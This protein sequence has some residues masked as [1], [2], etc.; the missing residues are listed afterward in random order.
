MVSSRWFLSTLLLLMTG[1]AGCAGLQPP[2]AIP[3][4]ISPA[5]LIKAVPQGNNTTLVN[6]APPSNVHQTLPDF[7]G[8]TRCTYN[9]VA[10]CNT[11]RAEAAFCFPG[12]AGIIQPGAG[13][14]SPADAA[15][16]PSAV[17]AAADIKAKE[18]GAQAKIQA[19]R[20]LAEFGCGC[21]N[22]DGSVETAFYDSL[23]D[24]TEEVRYEAVLAL[25]KV[26]CSCCKCKGCNEKACCSEKIQ[27]KL[28]ELAYEKDDMGCPV[29]PSER[30]RRAARLAL[31]ECG[32]VMVKPE[33][34]TAP[35]QPAVT[36]IRKSEGQ[37]A[38][39]EAAQG[40][41]P[42]AAGP[43]LP[44]PAQSAAPTK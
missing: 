38:S 9:T 8:I 3:K 34:M 25:R 41:P 28:R 11:L 44:P 37:P 13:I 16:Q 26:A 10:C 7:L 4:P 24:C 15:G 31:C 22:K 40:P 19:L 17:S 33:T 5:D 35:E 18:D 14:L 39:P 36:P 32:P 30:V 2:P 20:Y 6:V 43:P 42:A 1:Y 21:Y 29:E 12:L 23:G 27:K